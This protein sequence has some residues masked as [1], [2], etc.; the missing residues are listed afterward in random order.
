MRVVASSSAQLKYMIV[1][2]YQ[3]LMNRLPYIN[4]SIIS[5]TLGGMNENVMAYFM[6]RCHKKKDHLFALYID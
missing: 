1:S 3:N 5:T 4:L 6:K 2:H